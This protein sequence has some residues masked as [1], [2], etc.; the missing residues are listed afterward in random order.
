MST[1]VKL[2]VNIIEIHIM[3]FFILSKNQS[4]KLYKL[5]N[6]DSIIKEEIFMDTL[7]SFYFNAP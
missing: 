2:T 5:S 7:Y 6:T 1:G 4:L 3:Y